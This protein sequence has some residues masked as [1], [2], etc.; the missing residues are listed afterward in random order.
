MSPMTIVKQL[1]FLL[2]HLVRTHIN[3]FDVAGFF[4][5][6]IETRSDEAFSNRCYGLLSF[7]SSHRSPDVS[8]RVLCVFPGCIL[9]GLSGCSLW[10][11]STVSL[12]RSV[13]LSRFSIL[14]QFPNVSDVS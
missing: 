4:Q 5:Q 7:E 10:Q 1:G 9:F 14:R 3:K 11:F 13:A 2:M 6:A 8:F 12:E